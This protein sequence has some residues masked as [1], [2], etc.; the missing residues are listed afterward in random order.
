MRTPGALLAGWSVVLFVLCLALFTQE[1]D[2]PFWYH[3]DEGGK[4]EQIIS[5]KWNFHHPMLMLG[6]TKLAVGALGAGNDE[7]RAAQIGRWISAVFASVAAVALSLL[8]G[9]LRGPAAAVAAGL[10]LATH[11]QLFE[12]AHYLKEDTAL[13]AGIAL[14]LLGLKLFEERPTAARAAFLGV[15]CGLALSGKY[16]GAVMIALAL[17]VLI[18]SAREHRGR[19]F[20]TFL[21][22]LFL[23]ALLVN[24]P[25]LA[26]LLRFRES[27]GRETDLVVSGQRGMTRKVP[28]TEYLSAFRENTT[29][30]LWLFL[31]WHLAIFWRARREHTLARWLI[32]LFP[33]AFMLLLSFF[34]KSNDRYF[35]PA[36]ATFTFL[37]GLGVID[38]AVWLW[39]NNPA[40]RF[41]TAV[42][43]CLAFALLAQVVSLP[44]PLDWK[45]LSEYYRAFRHDDRAELR[46]WIE[47]NL[48]PDAVIAQDRSARLPITGREKD[49]RRQKP[50]R[51]KVVD[52]RGAAEGGGVEELLAQG[53]THVIASQND[54]GRYFRAGHRPRE[55]FADAFT[56]SRD[57]YDRLFR[58]GELL[59]KR[60][61]STVIYLHPGLEVYRLRK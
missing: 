22:A 33:V 40:L 57:F 38:G 7:Q 34:P 29:P 11:H 2:F 12:L 24:F 31:G 20:A 30:A 4:V 49:A 16:L 50:L 9:R 25:A 18:V 13:L 6:S 58:D 59:W 41:R 5:G 47:E 55:G 48:P 37:A 53:V 56:R 8:A 45:T 19:Q 44:H 1:N 21:G 46:A 10:L 51:Q 52:V 39:K 32:T 42:A 3:P 61:R 27:F 43:A 60:P 35:L 36:A 17:P 23:T 15:S 28:H 54:Y 26:D 14:S